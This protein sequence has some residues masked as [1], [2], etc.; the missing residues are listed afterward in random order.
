PASGPG[1]QGANG[2]GALPA[3]AGAITNVESATSRTNRRRGERMRASDP[4][5]AGGRDATYVTLARL[6]QG[7]GDRARREGY[8]GYGG[9]MSGGLGGREKS[10]SASRLPSA[11]S[12]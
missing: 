7:L 5:V 2:P 12:F 9:R 4:S 1:P 11:G 8:C 10:K 3:A 6:V